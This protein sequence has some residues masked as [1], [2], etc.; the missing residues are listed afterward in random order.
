MKE[1]STFNKK[2]IDVQI[3][4]DLNVLHFTFS[5]TVQSCPPVLHVYL[6]LECAWRLLEAEFS[7]AHP[8]EPSRRLEAALRL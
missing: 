6:M 5:A 2:F 7:T 4:S 1:L 8:P 3:Q